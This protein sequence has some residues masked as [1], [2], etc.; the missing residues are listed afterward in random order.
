MIDS[1]ILKF[2]SIKSFNVSR[3]TLKDL[4]DYSNEIILKNKNINLISSGTETSINTRHIF[5]IAQ[6]NFKKYKYII[7]FLGK[8]GKNILKD[9]LKSWQF[10]YEEKKSIT[11]NESTIVQIKN[12]KKKES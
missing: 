3:E 7:L 4:E 8:T 10:D 12:L 5:D 2:D 9:A 11:S 1:N 6:N